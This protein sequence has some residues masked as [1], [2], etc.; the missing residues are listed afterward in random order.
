MQ[1]GDEVT[2]VA[3]KQR[4]AKKP[5]TLLRYERRV[6]C[7]IDKIRLGASDAPIEELLRPAKYHLA[8]PY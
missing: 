7:Q 3:G 6:A 8:P 2:L 4:L 5:S 1:R